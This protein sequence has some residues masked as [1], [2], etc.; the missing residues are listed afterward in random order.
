MKSKITKFKNQMRKN[1]Q[2]FIWNTVPKSVYQ[3]DLQS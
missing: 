3:K 1:Q 2:S